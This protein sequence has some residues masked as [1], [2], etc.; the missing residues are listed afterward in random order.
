M[1]FYPLVIHRINIYHIVLKNINYSNKKNISSRACNY[2]IAV[3]M[4]IQNTLKYILAIVYISMPYSALH[5]LENEI[6]KS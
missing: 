3:T 6:A 2:K 4:L 5:V 1:A